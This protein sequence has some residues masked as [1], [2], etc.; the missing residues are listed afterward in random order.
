MHLSRLPEAFHEFRIVQMGDFHYGP[1]IGAQQI[2]HAVRLALSLK[3]DLTVFTGDFVSHPL[4]QRNGPAGARHAEPC[5]KILQQLLGTPTVAILGNHDYWN[6]P[7]IVAEI[8]ESHS[9]PVLRNR[10]IPL[11]R[12]GQRIW[13]IGVDDVYERAHDLEKSLQGIPPNETKIVAVHEPDF[14]D[15]VA[16]HSVDLQ[17]SGH[18]HG[19]Q[20]W[21]PGM[22]A[23]ILPR[24]AR[25]Y[26]RGFY[27]VGNLQHYTNR[28][29][30]AVTPPVRL[31]CRP[32]V[33]LITLVAQTSPSAV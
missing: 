14:A 13:I 21:I 31:N 12:N 1:Y 16:R 8:L 22:G 20:V 29:I 3:P 24:L 33:T 9:I 27:R 19:G 25:K 2:E 7:E 5:A 30:G 11:E 23:P 32:E 6:G 4:F 10:S 26:P 28:G 17:L 15:E 18:S